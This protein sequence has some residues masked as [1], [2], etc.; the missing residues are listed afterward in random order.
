[1]EEVTLPYFASVENQALIGKHLI[2]SSVNKV[3][4]SQHFYRKETDNQRG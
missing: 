1:M 3:G 4:I 2:L